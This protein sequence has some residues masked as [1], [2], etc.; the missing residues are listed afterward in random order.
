[1]SKSGCQEDNLVAKKDDANPATGKNQYLRTR[2]PAVGSPLGTF[3]P[4][5]WLSHLQAPAWDFTHSPLGNQKMGMLVNWPNNDV[6]RIK[7]EQEG[8]ISLEKGLVKHQLGAE[9]FPV[10]HH[11]SFFFYS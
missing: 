10:A 5:P 9:L 7:L 3:T 8:T 6:H 11:L 4:L 2:F 1:M